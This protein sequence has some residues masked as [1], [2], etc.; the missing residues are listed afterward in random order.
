[1]PR[2]VE[3]GLGRG[4]TNGITNEIRGMNGILRRYLKQNEDGGFH[5]LIQTLETFTRG[6]YMRLGEA[7]FG[8]LGEFDLAPDFKH[9]WMD[10]RTWKSLS[11]A[12]K[13]AALFSIGIIED[14]LEPASIIPLQNELP[15]SL[16][17]IY[18]LHEWRKM[19]KYARALVDHNEIKRFD[20][21]TFAVRDAS[22]V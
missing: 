14:D 15:V 19:M 9:L 13:K 20:E 17:S 16:Q 12:D 3:A 8:F 2:R 11:V 6:Q 18:T 21:E 10:E 1:M 22:I 5:L 4:N 7:I